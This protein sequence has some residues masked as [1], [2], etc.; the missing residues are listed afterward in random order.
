MAKT[1]SADKAVE[2]LHRNLSK[3]KFGDGLC[4]A[5]VANAIRATGIPVDRPFIRRNEG[6]SAPWAKDYDIPLKTAGFQE[7]AKGAKATG[8]PPI[9]YIPEKGDVAII[10][11]VSDP[12]HPAGHMAMYD[13][14]HWVSDFRQNNFWPGGLYKQER[15]SYVIYRHISK[16]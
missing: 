16:E 15:P 11:A 13:G 8:Y 4:A 6:A 5:N 7:V 10:Q 14:T 9:G 12:A 1:F 2:S 3:N